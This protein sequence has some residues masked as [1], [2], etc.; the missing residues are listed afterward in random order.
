MTRPTIESAI[1]HSAVPFGS[2]TKPTREHSKEEGSNQSHPE[3]D[4]LD[5][6]EGLG[7]AEVHAVL[8]G[9]GALARCD[10]WPRSRAAMEVMR[11]DG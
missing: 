2:A 7:D 5:V 1:S 6:D 3:Q 8:K 4:R 11:I 10:L 9:L